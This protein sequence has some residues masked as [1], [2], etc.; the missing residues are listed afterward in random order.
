MSAGS[1]ADPDFLPQ[2]LSQL[3]ANEEGVYL[4]Q[5]RCTVDDVG[6]L[7]AVK[8]MRPHQLN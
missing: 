7:G 3:E 4:Y 6:R 1:H 5:V 2:E 8:A